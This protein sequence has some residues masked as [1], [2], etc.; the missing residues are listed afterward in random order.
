MKS[1]TILATAF[2]SLVALIAFAVWAF[3]SA[4]NLSEVATYTLCAA[5][6]FGLGGLALSPASGARGRRALLAFSLRFSLG[7]LIYA[8]V[9]SISWFTFRGLR[10]FVWNRG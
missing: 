3:G 6:F 4:W 7:F 10:C 2:F 9:W 1:T 5:V 8:F